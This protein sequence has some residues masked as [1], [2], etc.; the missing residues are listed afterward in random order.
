MNKIRYLAC[1]CKNEHAPN[2]KHCWYCGLIVRRRGLT[3]DHLTP[4]SRSGS[5]DPG[6]IR[7]ACNSCNTKKAAMT[8]EEYRMLF[9][10]GY[11]F[12]GEVNPK[13]F[14]ED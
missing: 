3:R 5:N 2:L 11:L 9:T 1:L 4:K 13:S 10:P 7:P 12:W 6:N 14:V 8:L